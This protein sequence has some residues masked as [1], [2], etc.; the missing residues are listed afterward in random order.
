MFVEVSAQG[1]DM[2]QEQL[3]MSRLHAAAQ[4]SCQPVHLGAQ[5]LLVGAK[6]SVLRP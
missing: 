2:L 3:A 6:R 1:S 5:S 4:Y